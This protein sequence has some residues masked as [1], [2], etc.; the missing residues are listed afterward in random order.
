MFS[1]L[2]YEYFMDVHLAC[3]VIGSSP[4]QYSWQH[5]EM[6]INSSH[7]HK[8][9]IMEDGTL[10]IHN[11][12]S[13]DEG[14]Y[15][16]IVQNSVGKVILS[17]YL[18]DAVQYIAPRLPLG[19]PLNKVLIHYLGE[20]VMIPCMMSGRPP[21]VIMWTHSDSTQP[22]IS[23]NPEDRVYSQNGTLFFSSIK[24]EDQNYYRCTGSNLLGVSIQHLAL[25]VR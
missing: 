6:T 13:N 21:A 3:P 4:L 24:H 19:Q 8:Y 16:C 22:Q 23:T 1:E 18:R 9:C 12:S 10:T 7:N 11:I 14:M 25:V 17:I 15:L 5:N 20:M 2:F